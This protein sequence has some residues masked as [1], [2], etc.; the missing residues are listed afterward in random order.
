MSRSPE[1]LSQPERG[2][3]VI[4]D[5]TGYT[6]YLAGSELDH[7]QDVLADL[8]TTVVASFRPLLRLV[9]LEGDAA[10]AY[11]AQ[12]KIDG[13]T[14]LDVV[15]R[16]YFGFRRRLRDIHQATTC[17]CNA[18]VKIPSLD[19]K[20]FAHDGEFVRQRIAGHEEL[21]GTDV[22]LVHRLLKN[23]V[24]DTFHQQGYA[25]FTEAC[26]Q[27]MSVD[28]AGLRMQ[29]HMEVY[30]HIGEV[31]TFV[32]DLQ[33]R[34]AEEQERRRVYVTSGTATMEISCDLPSAPAVA[35]D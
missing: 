23:T 10:F 35:W 4:A 24:A 17:Q 21:A 28:P 14:L 16:C 15:E 11:T 2:F 22:I 13:S 26:I 25:L 31:R 6:Q 34:W 27:G 7:A 29:G 32:H 20:L 8:I 19:L 12:G 5:I 33:A 30:E 3:L 1:M 18:C 9:K